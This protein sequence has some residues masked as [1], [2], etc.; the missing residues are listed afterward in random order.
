MQVLLVTH[1]YSTHRGGIEIVAGEVARR[2]A[3]AHDIVWAASD[4]DP[5][6]SIDRIAYAPM[7]TTNI[8]ERTSGVP[9]PIWSPSAYARLWRLARETDVIHL[10]D[11]AYPGNWIAFIAAKRWRKPVV[12]TQHIGLVPYHSHALRL[13]QSMVHAILGRFILGGADQ[14]AFV[15]RVVRSYYTTFVR[16]RRPPIV[17]A[18]GVDTETF[19]AAGPSDRSRARAELGLDP[20]TTVLLFVG[21]FVEKKGLHILEALARRMHDVTWIL[22]GWGPIDPRAWNAPHVRVYE[23]RKGG[24]LVPLY[25][26]ADLLVL[27]SVGE[28]LPLVVQEAL[29]CGTPVLVGEDT[30]AAVDGP[31][32]IVIARRVEQDTSPDDTAGA[33]QAAIGRALS[34][35]RAD[36]DRARRAA[37]FA[38]ARWSWDS[39]ANSYAEVLMRFGAPTVK[40]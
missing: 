7:Q 40:S 3:P 4:C 35:S 11:F 22:A 34:E 2:L 12:V 26:A 18:N 23:N 20:S 13:A 28:G 21:R 15:S 6:P 1:Y 29:S 9:L 19:A 24:H 27:P 14:V 33:W 37:A 31:P 17:L 25:H 38:R 39:C 36:P 30:A 5:L 16:F 32:E 10:H 8:V